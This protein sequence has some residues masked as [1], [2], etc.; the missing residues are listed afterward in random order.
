MTDVTTADMEGLQTDI[1]T[2][3]SSNY[4]LYSD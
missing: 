3:N 4:A 1:D 2:F